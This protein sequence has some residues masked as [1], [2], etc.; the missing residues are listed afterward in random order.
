MDT[1]QYSLNA[2]AAC[3][4]IFPCVTDGVCDVPT[5]YCIAL[6][7]LPFIVAMGKRRTSD[8]RTKRG[9]G[10]LLEA[11]RS[12]RIISGDE[13]G[14]A[15]VL[16]E[17]LAGIA[18][19]TRHAQLLLARSCLAALPAAHGNAFNTASQLGTVPRA[20]DHTSDLNGAAVSPAAISNSNDLL[21][22]IR[23]RN[24]PATTPGRKKRRRIREPIAKDATA[25]ETQDESS[26]LSARPSTRLLHI[27]GIDGTLQTI[28]ELTEW[29]LFHREIY[30]H[31]GVSPPR[32]ILLHGPPG[33]GKTLLAHAIAGELGV[34]FLKVTGPEVVSSMSGESERKLRNLFAEARRLAPSIVFIDEIDA[35]ASRK[36]GA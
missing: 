32:G 7:K 29:P 27:G 12:G 16:A 5:V 1:V 17:N 33:C 28:R 34:P 4:R 20:P 10:I 35:I 6:C 25:P 26:Y 15:D 22:S 14:A 36:E 11:L 8:I 24:T 21:P 23:P 13:D 31:L 30:S 2:Y 9:V 18:R 19:Q 3:L